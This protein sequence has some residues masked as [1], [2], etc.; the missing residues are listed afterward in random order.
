MLASF[1]VDH[2]RQQTEY[3]LLYFLFKESD[4]KVQSNTEML[5][6]LIAQLLEVGKDRDR[7]L[8][9][10]KSRHDD[11]AFF[12]DRGRNGVHLFTTF[13][14]LIQG[15]DRP[16]IILFDALDEC[17]EYTVVT[18]YATKLTGGK[19]R[20]FLT[21]RPEVD[22]IF[23]NLP[24][25]ATIKMAAFED[26]S[27]YITQKVEGD[28]ALSSHRDSI[29]ETAYRNSGGMFRYA[30][31]FRSK[32]SLCNSNNLLCNSLAVGRVKASLYKAHS[33]ETGADAERN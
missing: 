25:T 1:M 18:N 7:L 27:K 14:E 32:A 30:A 28:P 11:R 29:I 26:I 22:Y 20:V 33:R 6:C 9:I 5:A 23:S 16:L 21:G 12:A 17:P 15:F 10:L 19:V 2:L 3:S 4:A 8:Q 24:N 31:K 13:E